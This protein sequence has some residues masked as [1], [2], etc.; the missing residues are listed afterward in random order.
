M[1]EKGTT[2]VSSEPKRFNGRK[3]VANY[4]SR[5]INIY[6]SPPSILQVLTTNPYFLPLLELLGFYLPK[7]SSKYKREK[8]NWYQTSDLTCNMFSGQLFCGTQRR[9]H[10]GVFGIRV[11]L[12]WNSSHMEIPSF[13]EASVG[14]GT[15]INYPFSSCRQTLVRWSKWRL[16]YLLNRQLGHHCSCRTNRTVSSWTCSAPLSPGSCLRPIPLA[17]RSEHSLPPNDP[18]VES[19]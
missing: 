13:G 11:L 17:P 6:C 12:I 3:M 10:W 14:F 18:P 2:Q 15:L 8:K 1:S 9:R 4:C 16:S 7:K 19:T 5:L